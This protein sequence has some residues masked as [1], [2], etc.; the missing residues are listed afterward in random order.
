ML[1]VLSE[2]TGGGSEYEDPRVVV[3]DKLNVVGREVLAHDGP[4]VVT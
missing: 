3:S 2:M 1:F 4:S